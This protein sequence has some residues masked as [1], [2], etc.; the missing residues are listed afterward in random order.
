MKP[1]ELDRY[2]KEFLAVTEYRD[3]APNKMFVEGL[4]PLKR[5]VTG[6]SL[7]SALIS[8][9]IAIEADFIIVHHPHGFWN[10]DPKLPIGVFGEK[11]RLLIQNQ[12]SVY[13]YHLPLDG[14]PVLGNNALLADAIGLKN[15]NGFIRSGEA[16]VGCY[17]SLEKAV[18]LDEFLKTIEAKVSPILHHFEGGGPTVQNIAICSGG[19]PQAVA[20][21]LESQTVDLYLTGEARETSQQFALEEQFHFVACGHH[22]TERFGVRA[23]GEHIAE[24]FHL[25]VDF[26]DV[27]NPV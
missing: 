19:A 2:L 5:G 14:H 23:L 24:Q 11:L 12:I 20:E 7:N 9:A 3:H 6:V 1:H 10:E 21:L 4:R 18:L 8:A 13:G 15:R 26:V 17:G 25:E 22:A 16:F 27:D